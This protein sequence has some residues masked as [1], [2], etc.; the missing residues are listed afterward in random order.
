MSAQQRAIAAALGS[1]ALAALIG[2]AA[3][4]EAHSAPSVP[5]T[6][7][8]GFVDS[9]ARCSAS[10]TLMAYGRTSRALVVICVEPDGGLQYRGVRLSDG[11]ALQMAAGRGSDGSIVALNEGVTYSVSPSTFL[12]SQGDTVLYRDSWTDFHQPRFS[13][14]STPSSTSPGTS[15]TATSSTAPSSSAPSSS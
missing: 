2:T 11:A 5:S 4:P 7:E 9:S 13:G 8:H 14:G 3:L 1:V 6:D 10:Q 12:V 15:T